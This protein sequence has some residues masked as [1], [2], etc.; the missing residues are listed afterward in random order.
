MESKL[1]S[2]QD[3]ETTDS[4]LSCARHSSARHLEPQTHA[5]RGVMCPDEG[6]STLCIECEDGIGLSRWL[7]SWISDL[8]VLCF[9]RGNAY[10]SMWVKPEFRLAM[11]AGSS[12]AW[13][14]VSRR[15]GP[16]ALR[17][18]RSMTTTPS[19]HFSVRLATENMCPGLSW[20]TWSLQ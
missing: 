20:W 16:L 18:A 6:L 14:T 12:S 10:Q 5:V 8:D 11:P 7:G 4:F 15:M 9:H 13:S 1:Q 17:P 19:P 3:N 2:R